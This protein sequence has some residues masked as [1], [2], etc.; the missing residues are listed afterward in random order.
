MLQFVEGTRNELMEGLDQI[1]SIEASIKTKPVKEQKLE[2]L[3]WVEDI[4]TGDKYQIEKSVYNPKLERKV[5][6]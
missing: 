3:I 2:E 4:E 5:R 1:D 6:A